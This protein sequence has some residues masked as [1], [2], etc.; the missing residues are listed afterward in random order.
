M[1]QDKKIDTSKNNT[2][3]LE[4]FS[5]PLSPIHL[6]KNDL[7]EIK[8]PKQETPKEAA[9]PAKSFANLSEKQK[10]SPFFTPPKPQE[11]AENKPKSAP[12]T[13]APETPAPET[14]KPTESPAFLTPREPVKEVRREA[15]QKIEPTVFSQQKYL[16]KDLS[17]NSAENFPLNKVVIIFAAFFFLLI[18]G[19]SGYY[20][21]MVKGSTTQPENNQTANIEPENQPV[22]PKKPETKP[23]ET[24]KLSVE[25]P[26]YLSLD[27]ATADKVYITKQIDTYLKKAAELQTASPIEIIF[28]DTN[29]QPLSF[30][31]FAE[32]IGL[33]FSAQ[34]ML[35]LKE[36]FS[37]F[38]FNDNNNYRLGIAIDSADDAALKTTMLK[39]ESNLV[40]ALEPLLK[41]P[42]NKDLLFKEKYTEVTHKS[43]KIRYAN[44]VSP[45]YLSV[46]YAIFQKKLVIA[47]T[48]NMIG[49]ILDYLTPSPT[50]NSTL[51]SVKTSQTETKVETSEEKTQSTKTSSA[52]TE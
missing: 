10:T 45:E 32:K 11:I 22:P 50:K 7:E 1:F 21:W 40:I 13:P 4:S 41:N 33:T 15:P 46:D 3:S 17:K 47:T 35:S 2:N 6:M 9:A 44:I 25:K 34:I 48:K 39:E 52:T 16:Q 24:P 51:D 27:L 29:N 49:A 38:I 14:P 19:A 8:N 23:E 42:E 5:A 20:F 30:K 36:P 26:N 31:A 12:E 18:V 43:T 28:T 37:L